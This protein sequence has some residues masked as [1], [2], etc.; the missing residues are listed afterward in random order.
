MSGVL[1]TGSDVV[2]SDGLG[3]GTG[4]WMDSYRF[5]TDPTQPQEG[6]V[7]P[8]RLINVADGSPVYVVTNEAGCVASAEDGVIYGVPKVTEGRMIDTLS[9]MGQ[10]YPVYSI[11]AQCCDYHPDYEPE[12]VETA[13]FGVPVS[14]H[15]LIRVTDTNSC[16]EFRCELGGTATPYLEGILVH[17]GAAWTGCVVGRTGVSLCIELA[18]IGIG[19][20]SFSVA[21]GCSATITNTPGIFCILPLQVRL[22]DLFDENCCDCGGTPTEAR[23]SVDIVGYCDRRHPARL[24]DVIGT[25]PVYTYVENCG[26]LPDCVPETCCSGNRC[27]LTATLTLLSGLCDCLDGVT[28]ILSPTFIGP[29]VVW[30]NNRWGAC[31]CEFNMVLTCV[32]ESGDCGSF[33]LLIESNNCSGNASTGTVCGCVEEFEIEMELVFGCGTACSPPFIPCCCDEAGSSGGGSGVYSVII[34]R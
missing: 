5:S 1:G 26:D 8:A 3:T 11:W 30:S 34:R 18:C 27:T 16:P 21:G 15:L 28:V 9:V 4:T 19:A 6:S 13:C 22:Q 2:E 10:D 29:D 32:S 20:L 33:D 31:S 14:K 23:I 24:I 25:T 7:Q 17:D 12:Y